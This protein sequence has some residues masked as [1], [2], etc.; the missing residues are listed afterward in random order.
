MEGERLKSPL[1]QRILIWI[2]NSM[3]VYVFAHIN[4]I[5]HCMQY[6]YSKPWKYFYGNCSCTHLKLLGIF[7]CTKESK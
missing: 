7:P 2:G 3:T 1:D 5:I 4:L 6:L